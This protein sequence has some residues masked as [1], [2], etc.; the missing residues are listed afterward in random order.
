MY[1]YVAHKVPKRAVS[2]DVTSR[3][4]AGA[5]QDLGQDSFT[6]FGPSRLNWI[7]AI[8]NKMMDLWFK[9]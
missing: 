2:C 4:R 1:V 7:G 9:G 3:S 5:C 6:Q 8:Y